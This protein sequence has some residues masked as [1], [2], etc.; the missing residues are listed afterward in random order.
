MNNIKYAGVAALFVIG[1]AGDDPKDESG[2]ET[3]GTPVPVICFQEQAVED[4]QVSFI[5]DNGLTIEATYAITPAAAEATGPTTALPADF[6]TADYYG[7]VDPA[8][9]E[10]WFA[11]WTAGGGFD[12][13]LNSTP[14]HPLQAEIEGGQ[15]KPSGENLCDQ[16]DA[17]YVNGGTVTIF[18][19]DFPVCVVSQPITADVTWPNN[20]VFYLTDSITIGTGDVQLEGGQPAMNATL[21]ISAGTQVYGRAG[22]PTSLVVSRGSEIAANGTADQPILFASAI[23]NED[24]ITD[25]ASAQDVAGRG[26]WGG[27][28]LS[29]F[30]QTNSGDANGELLTEAAPTDAERWFG[31]NDNGDSSGTIRYAIIAESGFEFRKDEEV[32]GLTI[33]AAGSGTTIEYLQVIGS[34]DDGIEWFG[35]AAGGKY[36]LVEGQDDDAL[37]QDLGW[38]GDVQFAIVSMGSENGD[39]GI[40]SDN[41]GDNFDA[42]PQTAPNF[43]NIT[44]FGDIGKDSDTFAALHR[45]GWRGKIYRSVYTDKADAAF[46]DGCLDIDDSLPSELEYFDAIFNCSP[47][48]LMACGDDE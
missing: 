9:A 8:A 42:A 45:E 11:G 40:E 6:D 14:F 46:E 28:I 27:I 13:A 2:T 24:G 26:E 47:G 36:I 1:C 12:G 25:A 3:T 23:G 16:L 10:G 20:H 43:A 32:Q 21:T 18:G 30:G 37:D 44:I 4:G 17:N 33:E 15:I 5:E 31:G 7:A 39:R 22:E 48:P 38:T 34:E 41:N 35:G 19:Q 29:G